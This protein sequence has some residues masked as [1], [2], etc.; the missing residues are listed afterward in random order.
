MINKDISTTL[1]HKLSAIL[2]DCRRV[3]PALEAYLKVD[4]TR[5]NIHFELLRILS[6]A[7]S[8]YELLEPDK[9]PGE[10]HGLPRSA[11]LVE[12]SSELDIRHTRQDPDWDFRPWLSEK[13]NRLQTAAKQV[14]SYWLTDPNSVVLHKEA[15][16]T[17]RDWLR[18]LIALNFGELK[19]KALTVF[20]EVCSDRIKSNKWRRHLERRRSRERL[21]ILRV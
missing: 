12:P 14:V 7:L 8:A 20:E 2:E 4:E 11:C 1:T 6:N 18:Q 5:P 9:S 16:V 3:E 21:W 10:F 17:A 19:Q 13:L 15:R